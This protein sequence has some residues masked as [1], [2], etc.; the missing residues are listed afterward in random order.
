[1][2]AGGEDAHEPRQ[3]QQ[4]RLVSVDGLDQ[5]RL[6]GGTVR[7]GAMVHRSGGDAALCGP[8]QPGSSRLVAQHRGHLRVPAFSLAGLLDRLHVRATARD[9]D[10]DAF[11]GSASVSSDRGLRPTRVRECTWIIRPCDSPQTVISDDFFRDLTPT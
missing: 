11:H 9:Q 1:V 10:H 4:V 6:E 8:G 5:G 2:K 7:I 3:Q